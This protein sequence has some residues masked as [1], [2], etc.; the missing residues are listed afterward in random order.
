M[1]PDHHKALSKAKIALMSSPDSAFFSTVCFS[2]KHIWDDTIPTAC[3]DGVE[4]RFNPGFFMQQTPA[5]Q[6]G[7]LLHETLHVAFLH[8]LRLQGRNPRKW[9]Y[10]ADYVT[11]DILI[12]KGFQL[13]EGALYDKKYHGMGV[14]QVYDL[15]PDPPPEDNSPLDLRACP[16]DL[17]DQEVTE[18]INDILIRA[19]LQA[20]IED[21][22]PGSIPAQLQR[23]IDSLL[24]PKLPWNRIL[25]KYLRNMAKADYSFRKP[26]RRFFPDY[27]LPSLHSEGLMEIAVAVDSSGSVKQEKFTRFVSENDAILRHERPESLTLIQ[28]D[29]EIKSTD[30]ITSTRELAQIK[31]TGRGG[32]RIAPVIKWAREHK[33]NVLIIF[34]D[35]HFRN[36]SPDPGVPIIWIIDENPRFKCDYGKIIHYES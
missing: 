21:N 15:I 10:A 2:L 6:L 4:I 33:P 3:T 17:T 36:D 14:E 18:Q 24:K 1:E 11:N 20:Q 8:P 32:T 35:G 30:V 7:L 23:Y 9:N 26:N 13:P 29:T 19:E 31:F 5:Q 34:T 28:F 25:Q 16:A 12:E 22:S 27:H